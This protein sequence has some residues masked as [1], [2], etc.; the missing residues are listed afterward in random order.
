MIGFFQLGI[1]SMRALNGTLDNASEMEGRGEARLAWS[2]PSVRRLSLAD[3]EFDIVPGD[4]GF[5]GKGVKS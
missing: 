4:D 1:T 5:L 2:Q 3:A